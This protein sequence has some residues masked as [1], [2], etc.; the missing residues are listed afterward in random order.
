MRTLITKYTTGGNQMKIFSKHWAKFETLP[1]KE[2]MHMVR[3][4]YDE[5]STDRLTQILWSTG[6]HDLV[7]QANVEGAADEKCL[8]VTFV[9]YVTDGKGTQHQINLD[10]HEITVAV[11]FGTPIEDVVEELDTVIE[12]VD[13]I[14]GNTEEVMSGI[15]AT[16]EEIQ[17]YAEKITGSSF[18]KPNKSTFGTAVING[19]QVGFISFGSGVTTVD[20]ALVVDDPA[21]AV[22]SYARYIG[23]G[24]MLVITACPASGVTVNEDYVVSNNCEFASITYGDTCKVT[25]A[26][27]VRDI[28]KEVIGVALVMELATEEGLVDTRKLYE[29]IGD[30]RDVITAINGDTID[31]IMGDYMDSYAEQLHAILGVENS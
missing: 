25:N 15:T 18:D 9:D 16:R 7:T 2:L 27:P 4:I 19:A 24:E 1:G 30:L 8:L 13:S 29:T 12:K 17:D 6:T 10:N 21:S 5:S 26:V 22:G 11:D 20:S 3:L 31:H 14:S 28:Q 23:Q